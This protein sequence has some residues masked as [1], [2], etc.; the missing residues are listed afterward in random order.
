MLVAALLPLLLAVA[1]AQDAEVQGIPDEV[2]VVWGSVEAR[3]EL[4]AVLWDL[5]YR[6]SR[7]RQG[8]RVILRST[9]RDMPT[10][11]LHDSGWMELREG[12][13]QADTPLGKTLSRWASLNF[14][15]PRKVLGSKSK[16]LERCWPLVSLW[17]AAL[18]AEGAGD[19]DSLPSGAN[20]DAALATLGWDMT[21]YTQPGDIPDLDQRI[22]AR[23]HMV[24]FRLGLTGLAGI[25]LQD[26]LKQVPRE[27][28]L[29]REDWAQANDDRPMQN[30]DG[31]PLVPPSR[32]A[33][34]LK[35]AGVL[36]GER[37]LEL[38]RESGYRAAVLAALGARV[39]RVEAEPA[40]A[41][42]MAGRLAEVGVAAQVERG[43]LAA[44]WAQGG[45]YDLILVEDVPEADLALLATQLTDTGRVLVVQGFELSRHTLVDGALREQR[46]LPLGNT[47]PGP[48]RAFVPDAGV[49]TMHIQEHTPGFEAAPTGF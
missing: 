42:A 3:K 6:D 16:L 11:I 26:A 14:V 9:R 45:P 30:P 29:D 44:G 19:P 13:F 1:Q 36:A 38:S 17:Q 2:M 4:E 10:V 46:F 5:G 37:V 27:L 8:D 15:N 20:L 49:P 39:I 34:Q 12:F 41:F 32:L 23:G 31:R 48:G 43:P 35:S 28:F 18:A 40:E 25:E 7:R 24:D 22:A 47:V 21:H 33:W